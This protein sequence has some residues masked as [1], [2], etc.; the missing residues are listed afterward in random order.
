MSGAQEHRISPDLTPREA[1]H[2]L[3]TSVATVWSMIADGRLTSYSLSP[4]RG[5]ARRI[6]WEAIEAI[7]RGV[8]PVDAVRQADEA[9]ALRRGLSDHPMADR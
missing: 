6:R 7:R 4:K 1:A 9:V 8:D 5:A 2:R 3:G